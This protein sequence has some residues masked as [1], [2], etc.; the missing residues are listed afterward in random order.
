M[1]SLILKLKAIIKQAVERNPA[2]GLLFSGGL[3]TS[4]LAVLNPT[5]LAI[6]VSLESGGEDIKYAHYLARTLNL[7]HFHRIV[8][9]D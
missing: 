7:N 8:S 3:D 9:L 2:S 6:T 4:I 1:N 5:V